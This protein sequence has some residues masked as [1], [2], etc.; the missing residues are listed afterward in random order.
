MGGWG[1]LDPVGSAK[2]AVKRNEGG[3]WKGG[4][5]DAYDK[6][7]GGYDKYGK[8]IPSIAVGQAV[9]DAAGNLI[10]SAKGVLGGGGAA[11]I[12]DHSKQQ[13]QNLID[14]LNRERDEVK[15]R[16]GQYHQVGDIE[17]AN[18]SDARFNADINMGRDARS[19]AMDFARQ[20]G[21]ADVPSTAMLQHRLATDRGMKQSLSLANSQRNPRA[22]RDAINAQGQLSATSSLQ[23]GLIASQEAQAQ[24]Q[25]QAQAAGIM[26]GLRGQDISGSTSQNQ[27]QLQKAL[28]N[29]A[30]Q[31]KAQLQNAA[32]A[33]QARGQDV[34]TRVAQDRDVASQTA[35]TFAQQ[36]RAMGNRMSAEA[37]VSSANA[38]AQAQREGAVIGTLGTLGAAVFSDRKLKT[39]IQ[40]SDDEIESF[41]GKLTANKYLYKNPSMGAGEKYG[42]MAQDLEKSEIGD[43]AVIESNQGKMVDYDELMPAMLSSLGFLNRKLN[44]LGGEDA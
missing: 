34:T 31:N 24:A 26:T 22:L 44:Y 19:G 23:S 41:L 2:K 4:V 37:G 33:N 38:R 36:G 30:A 12:S 5:Q 35:D 15:G 8:Y 20:L 13:N 21:N 14:A 18:A 29:Q 32:Q 10:E 28:A 39:N 9:Y 11:G 7:K 17:R 3:G 43:G 40:N 6:A 16:R 1:G 27:M 25:R 42:P